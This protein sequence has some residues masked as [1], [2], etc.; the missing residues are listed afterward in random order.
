MDTLEPLL[1]RTLDPKSLSAAQQ[2]L[3]VRW[4]L[5]VLARHWLSVRDLV[6]VMI[7]RTTVP[8]PYIAP[9]K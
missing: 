1:S 4:K 5:H 3:V 6:E 8:G 9:H 7:G 2:R